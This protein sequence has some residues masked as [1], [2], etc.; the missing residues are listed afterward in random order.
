M[1][2][3]NAGSNDQFIFVKIIKVFAKTFVQVQN[4]ITSSFLCH[5]LLLHLSS[6]VGWIQHDSL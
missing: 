4:E 5:F 1:S 6:N 3:N 2:H